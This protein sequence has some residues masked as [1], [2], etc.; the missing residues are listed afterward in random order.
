[1]VGLVNYTAIFAPNETMLIAWQSTMVQF[2]Y[3]PVYLRFIFLLQ[4]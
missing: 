4:F 1:V 3:Q 2:S